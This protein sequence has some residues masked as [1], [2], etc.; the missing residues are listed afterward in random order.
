MNNHEVLQYAST[1]QVT[2]AHSKVPFKGETI[3][4]KVLLPTNGLCHV[5]TAS[6]GGLEKVYPLLFNAAMRGEGFGLDEIPNFE[7]FSSFFMKERAMLVV[8]KIASL[9]EE[10]IAVAIIG[11]SRICR[12]PDPSS[13]SVYILVMPGYRNKGTG[14]ELAHLSF[15]YIKES[16]Y[17]SIFLA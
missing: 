10:T 14:T 12:H 4:Q 13:C 17:T 1:N 16:G 8:D 9:S 5:H 2:F 6:E 7:I 11:P 15:R 3:S